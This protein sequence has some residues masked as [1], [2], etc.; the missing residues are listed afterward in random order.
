M[1]TVIR[2]MAF[3]I[4]VSIFLGLMWVMVSYPDIPSTASEWMWIFVLAL[5]LQL[6]FE[7]LGELLWNNKASRFV[8]RKTAAQAFSL[9]RI[10][11][12]LFLFLMLVGLLLAARFGWDML[13][14]SV[15]KG[16][17]S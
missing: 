9:I 3:Y 15:E 5:L 1:H 17:N 11:Y 12:A 10:V 7:F 8:E 13:R 14:P 6:A 4:G 16:R 2:F